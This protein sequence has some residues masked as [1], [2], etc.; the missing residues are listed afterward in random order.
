MSFNIF[1]ASKSH[2]KNQQCVSDC[3]YIVLFST[4]GDSYKNCLWKDLTLTKDKGLVCYVVI[5]LSIISFSTNFAE[6]IKT[7]ST[8][9]PFLWHHQSVATHDILLYMCRKTGRKGEVIETCKHK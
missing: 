4:V 9:L 6:K 3:K 2:E 7:S 1:P 8:F 5:Y